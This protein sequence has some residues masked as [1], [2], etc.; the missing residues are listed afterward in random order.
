VIA[1]ID[2]S[3]PEVRDF[4]IENARFFLKEYRVDGFR[5]DQVS[6]IDHDGAPHG[7]SFCQQLTSA[8][9]HE[10]PRALHLAEYWN[11]NP[12]VIKPVPEGVGFDTTL[13]DGLRIAIRDV[14]GNSRQPDERP[15]N[16]T[17]LARSLWP[18]GFSQHWQFVQGPENHDIVYQGREERMAQL[19]HPDHRHSWYGRSRARVATGLCLTA[20]GIPMLFM[21]QEFLEEK[22]WS[23]NF[24]FHRHLLIDWKS[25]EEGDKA[26]IDFLRFVRELLALRWRQPALRVLA[27]QRWVEG[28]GHDVMVVVHLAVFNRYNYRIGFPGGGE[29]REV[30]NSDVYD[31][32]VNPMVTGNGGR[33]WADPA[34]MHGFS[35]SAALVLPA[36]SLLVF[37]R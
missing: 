6:V 3:K 37:A 14:I 1:V 36:N 26:R 32:W 24:E 34:P 8:L 19:G 15:L 5:Y 20:P 16:M 17:A 27:F 9:K 33:V 4:L 30:L 13:T 31:N 21:G 25:L 2:Y 18:E 11:V 35:H 10:N 23:D 12:W 22:Q 7:W 29:W 28:Q